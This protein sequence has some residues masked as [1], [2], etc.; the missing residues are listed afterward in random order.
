LRSETP[1]QGLPAARVAARQ[2]T[3][4]GANSHAVVFYEAV[5]DMFDESVLDDFPAI[6]EEAAEAFAREGQ[7]RRAVELLEPVVSTTSR[8]DI[9]GR[10]HGRLGVFYHRAGDGH[11]AVV[12]LE[13]GLAHLSGST[14]P[15]VLRERL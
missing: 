9:S 6:A 1:Q 11:R 12:H 14:D 8:G 3:E 5:L 15:Q 10:L 13:R 4:N 7:H 2:A